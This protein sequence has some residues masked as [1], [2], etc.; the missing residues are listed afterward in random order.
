[1]HRRH[2]DVGYRVGKAQVRRWDYLMGRTA[3]FQNLQHP[4]A[5]VPQLYSPTHR[6]RVVDGG[7]FLRIVSTN[8]QGWVIGW[9]IEGAG[10]RSL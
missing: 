6:S 2:G 5:S 9:P 1:M 3:A 7:R 4:C 10:G 8:L